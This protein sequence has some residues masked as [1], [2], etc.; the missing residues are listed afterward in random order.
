MSMTTSAFTRDTVEFRSGSTWCRAWFYLPSGASGHERCPAVVMGHGLGATR[1]LGLAPYAERFVAQGMAV[2]VFTYRGLGDSGGHPRQVLSMKRQ[3]EDWDA[4]IAYVKSRVEIDSERMAVWGSS[5]G[6]GHAIATAAEHPELTAVV[7]Q[8]PFTDGVASARALGVRDSLHMVGPILR[9]LVAA[10]LRRGPVTIPV[11]GAVG[12]VALMSAPDALD[13]MYALV[14]DDVD[15]RNEA[16][17]RSVLSILKYRPGRAARKIVAPALIC[18]S[19]SDTV[20]PAGP[21]EAYARR[22]PCGDVRLYPAGHFEFYLGE[23]FEQLVRE[24]TEF[25]VKHLHPSVPGTR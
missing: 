20:A 17:A 16:A 25:L 19:S 1:E 8:C 18:I 3:L 22:T 11:A 13:G 23:P 5:L 2:L 4:A 10:G 21:T 15:W 6:G 24:Q 14:P 9:D 7:A 12:E